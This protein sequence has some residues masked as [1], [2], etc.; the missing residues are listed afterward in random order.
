MDFLVEQIVR[1]SEI[2]EEALKLVAERLQLLPSAINCKA[3]F[4]VFFWDDSDDD[5]ID[6]DDEYQNDKDDNDP[7]KKH[8]LWLYLWLYLWL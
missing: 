2:F 5:N 7:K 8:H 4:G 6:G 1:K 3:A